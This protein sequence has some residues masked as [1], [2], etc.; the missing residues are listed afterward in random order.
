MKLRKT[1]YDCGVRIGNI[2]KD[3]CDIERCSVCGGKG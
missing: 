3:G 2:H 1:C